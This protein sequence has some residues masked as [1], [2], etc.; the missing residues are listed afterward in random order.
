FQ[1]GFWA[2]GQKID[3]LRPETFQPHGYSQSQR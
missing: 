1:L 3:H 2:I